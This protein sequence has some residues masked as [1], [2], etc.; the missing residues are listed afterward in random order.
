MFAKL[1]LT[2]RDAVGWLVYKI[3]RFLLLAIV[4]VKRVNLQVVGTER[5]PKRGAYVLALVPH[6]SFV[7]GPLIIMAVRRRFIGMG[8]AELLDWKEWHVI[9]LLFRLMGHIPVQRDN[10]KSRKEAFEAGIATIRRGVPVF[11]SPPG[12]IRNPE[13][14]DVWRNGYARMSIETGTPMALVRVF[15][16]K[17]FMDEGPEG[18]WIFDWSQPMAVII[19]AVLD[20]NDFTSADELDAE[21]QR[22]YETIRPPD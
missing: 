2:C 16:A 17:A 21:A 10:P 22:I 14:R 5:L 13:E 20:P 12:R 3:V 6:T 1:R 9:S 4:K 8:M 15:G 7:D 11:I 18:E 19:G